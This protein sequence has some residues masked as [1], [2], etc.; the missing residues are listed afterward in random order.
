MARLL[1]IVFGL[2]VLSGCPLN[3]KLKTVVLTPSQVATATNREYHF[4]EDPFV[5]CSKTSRENLSCYG[6]YGVL[7]DAPGGAPVAV[8]LLHDYGS[9]SVAGI[10]GCDERIN[11]IY[12][13][14]FVF[15]LAPLGAT[16]HVV[17]AKLKYQGEVHKKS[18]ATQWSASEDCIAKLGIV[19]SS[20]GGFNVPAEF[21]VGDVSSD[22]F[23]QGIEVTA[24]V[25]D[26]V[27]GS[28]PNHGLML[29][30]PKEATGQ[31]DND[32]CVAK[33]SNL[34]LEVQIDVGGN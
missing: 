14:L 18:D 29:V 2:L 24:I 34:Q 21:L 5:S 1:L 31:N 7:P 22:G 33:L 32:R 19:T 10:Q 3:L 30:G 13:G 6:T 16:P 26:W 25:R 17:T 15:D 28:S 27:K 8:G 4:H 23:S 12:R 20:W 9:A 11:C